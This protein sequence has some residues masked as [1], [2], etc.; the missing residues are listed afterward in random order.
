MS[1][2]V[3]NALCTLYQIKM[4]T[5]ILDSDS[6]ALIESLIPL[7][8][9]RMNQA[10]GRE[11]MWTGTK[12][13]R[14]FDTMSHHVVLVGSDLRNC[15]TVAM[16]PNGQPVTLQASI[17]YILRPW[18]LT[19]TSTSIRL[20]DA[21]YLGSDFTRRMNVV[22]VA[23]TGDWGIWGDLADVPADINAA[24]IEC[25]LSW[26]DKPV[27]DIAGIDS[28][29][30]RSIMPSLSPMW[31]IPMSAWRKLQPYSVNFGVY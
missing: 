15:T 17:D 2:P 1:S 14:V 12:E 27:S 29:S 30:P 16:D 10:T 28:L 9:S 7:A 13:T 21:L 31:D 3:V 22:Q 18:R 20:S 5:G 4:R 23:V 11:F 26:I 25:V 8:L 19:G 6:D 24:A